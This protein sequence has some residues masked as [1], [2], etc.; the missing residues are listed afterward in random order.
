MFSFDGVF[1]TFHSMDELTKRTRHDKSCSAWWKL[2]KQCQVKE[3]RIT[4]LSNH[5]RNVI[6]RHS[7]IIWS[8]QRWWARQKPWPC[9]AFWELHCN[10]LRSLLI[11]FSVW[12]VASEN[13]MTCGQSV[14]VATQPMAALIMYTREH[15]Q[16]ICSLCNGS[17]N[18]QGIKKTDITE[19]R[20]EMC[21]RLLSR[22]HFSP[23]PLQLWVQL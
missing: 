13:T 23:W 14:P 5:P 4:A 16:V 8:I 12:T 2:S 6:H 21:C 19:G 3:T 20:N 11:Y 22:P 18:M 7:S 1:S 9:W 15:V 10:L 17:P